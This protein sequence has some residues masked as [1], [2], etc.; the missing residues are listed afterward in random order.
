MEILNLN[1]IGKDV[2]YIIV[3]G[4]D[5]FVFVLYVLKFNFNI[6]VYMFVIFWSNIVMMFYFLEKCFM[7]FFED[8]VGEFG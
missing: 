6:F 2:F 5:I 4:N 1:L 3:I 7:I 8:I